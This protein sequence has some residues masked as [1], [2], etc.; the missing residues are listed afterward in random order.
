MLTE[1]CSVPL[2]QT[3]AEN[4]TLLLLHFSSESLSLQTDVF[5]VKPLVTI[6]AIIS[7]ELSKPHCTLAK[8]SLWVLNMSCFMYEPPRFTLGF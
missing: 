1:L 2:V 6:T 4:D 5:N 8:L 3:K 7:N